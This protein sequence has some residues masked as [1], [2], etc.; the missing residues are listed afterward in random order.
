MIEIKLVKN[1][2]LKKV[3]ICLFCF[4]PFPLKRIAAR[5]YIDGHDTD[6]NAC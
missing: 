6:W 1:S 4:D 5:V 3:E 2:N